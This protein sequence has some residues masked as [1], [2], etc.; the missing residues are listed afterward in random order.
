LAHAAAS[1]LVVALGGDLEAVAVVATISSL[2]LAT[3]PLAL[4]FGAEVGI[5]LR[6]AAQALLAFV[7]PAAI[8]FGLA[9]LVV[10]FDRS[11]L[12]GAAAWALGG[13]AYA[14][15]LRV[16]HWPEVTG[17]AAALRPRRA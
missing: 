2:A 14:I 13:A 5:A 1:G 11:L 17:L 12:R 10:G 16:R 9:A 6:P 15:W 8:T 4:V 7:V 3:V